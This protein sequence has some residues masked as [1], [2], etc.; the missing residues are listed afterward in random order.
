MRR[1]T[2]VTLAA[3][4]TL[5]APGVASAAP[6][7]DLVAGSATLTGLTPF[8]LSPSHVHVNAKGNALEGRGHAFAR[9]EI[10]PPVGD[11]V[12]RGAVQCVDAVGKQATILLRIEDS[13]T[14]FVPHGTLLWRKIIDNGEGAGDPPDQSGVVPAAAPICPPATTPLPA[15]P[16]DQGN[17]V[18]H[19]GG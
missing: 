9:F 18:V 19:D 12:L 4:A 17:F 16:I 8:G 11:V 15:A 5:A 14:P 2:V 3:A 6:G 7:E 1:A 10:G 13:N